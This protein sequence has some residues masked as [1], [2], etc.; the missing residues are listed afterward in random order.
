MNTWQKTYLKEW[1]LGMEH[2][3]AFGV[4]AQ[5]W[6]ETFDDLIDLTELE[7]DKSYD[8]ITC[9]GQPFSQEAKKIT[10]H[11]VTMAEFFCTREEY[12]DAENPRNMYGKSRVLIWDFDQ[13]NERCTGNPYKDMI[14][15][16]RHIAQTYHIMPVI[17]Y[18]G[19]TGY[20][21]MVY[22][23]EYLGNEYQKATMEWQIKITEDAGVYVPSD[24]ER[25]RAGSKYEGDDKIDNI[26]W[27]VDPVVFKD[28]TKT[29]ILRIPF[30]QRNNGKYCWPI[31]IETHDPNNMV[32]N[33]DI[34]IKIETNDDILIEI[35]DIHTQHQ[36]RK[37]RSN[38]QK[39]I[40]NIQ[41]ELM[42]EPNGYVDFK[43]INAKDVWDDLY[44][45]GRRGECP[46]Q[47]H[48]AKGAVQIYSDGVYCSGCCQ[49]LSAWDL[50]MKYYDD[51][52]KVVNYLRSI[53]KS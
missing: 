3:R 9:N 14:K 8:F 36:V 49:Q 33:E 5:G 52:D 6:L 16:A 46:I 24:K 45:G 50:A 1:L 4:P 17:H 11:Y 35:L 37:K 44:G 34:Q 19:S 38:R 32:Y 15:V 42:G 30:I 25:R 53:G 26:W 23:S 21:L 18:S 20:H 13:H 31:D 39:R 12:R 40:D 2:P 47:G 10:G 29:R 7:L 28:S 51:K 22:L 27:T 48:S 41:W 43:T